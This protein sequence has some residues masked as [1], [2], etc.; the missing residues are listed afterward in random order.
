[1]PSRPFADLT[2]RGR[3]RRLRL[4]ARQAL[5]ERSLGDCS[6]EFLGDDTNT[7]FVARAGDGRRFVVRIGVHGPIA[8]SPAEAQAETAWLASL[9][10]S[11]LTVPEPVPDRRG[12]LVSR[13]SAPGVEGERLVVVFRWLPGSLLEERL[14][15]AN[16]EA[17][18]GLAA[19][20]HRHAAGFRPPAEPSLPRYDRLF[21]FDQPEVLFAPEPCPLLPPD[22]LAVLR[23]AA[24][25]VD[26][27]I[28]RL[29]ATGPMRLLHGDL[30]VWNVLV[31]RG[32]L[33][34]IDFEDL[35]WGWPVQDIGTALYYLHHRPDFA[36]I[37]DGFRRGYEQVARWPET[38]PGEL[39]T[40]IAGRALVL[41]N[42]VLQMPPET[43]GGLDVP[44]FFARA[45]RRL[46]AILDGG[47]FA[48]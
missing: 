27:A 6:L 37:R 26:A 30:H 15:P 16:L 7:L 14:T 48:G 44:D 23:R 24:E 33:A 35:M 19:S 47:T 32:Q 5:A 34:A 1:V 46:R 12:D 31:H 21:P 2:R 43:L 40:F 38:E 17:Y 29:R 4:I 18:G 13:L 28:A 9:R 11:G 36:A 41:A 42:D 45:E 22:R 20:L 3:A 10:A 8:H 39:E 25:R